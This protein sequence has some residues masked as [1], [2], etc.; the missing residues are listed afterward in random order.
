[1]LQRLEDLLGT[2]PF[3]KL[4]KRG[5]VLRVYA[6]ERVEPPL[7]EREFNPGVE[8]GVLMNVAREFAAGDCS[9]EVDAAW[10]LWQHSGEWKVAPLSVT[11]AAIGPEFDNET[12]DHLRIEFGI[13][14]HF[15][16]MNGLAGSA[17]MAQ[18]NLRSLL[19][20]VSQVEESLPLEKRLLWSES[21]VNFADLLTE[22][23]SRYEVN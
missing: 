12:G 2:F 4:A 7:V 23:L 9:V 22:T 6:S 18:S 11:L 19:H 8:P 3:S 13:D 21:G 1:M 20:L 16:P 14:A 10:D 17:R 5:P 15:L